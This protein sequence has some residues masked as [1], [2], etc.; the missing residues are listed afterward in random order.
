MRPERIRWLPRDHDIHAG[1]ADEVS[2]VMHE[3]AQDRSFG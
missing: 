3:T 1:H 2:G